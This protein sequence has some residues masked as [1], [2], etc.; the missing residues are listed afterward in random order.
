MSVRSIAVRLVT[1]LGIGT[2]SCQGAPE[3]A[4]SASCVSASDSLRTVIAQLLARHDLGKRTKDVA[5]TTSVLADSIQVL[6]GAAAPI[7]GREALAAI[8]RNLF[9]TLRFDSVVYVG[10]DVR[11]CGAVVIELGEARAH[12]TPLGQDPQLEHDRYTHVWERRERGEWQLML[13]VNQELAVPATQ[14]AANERP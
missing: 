14:A 9:R 12:Y 8:Y 13:A 4:A 6:N 2:V 7:R 3:P 11:D 10:T 1:L 5:V